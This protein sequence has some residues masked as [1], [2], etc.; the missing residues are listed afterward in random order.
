MSD[1]AEI[2]ALTTLAEERAL[3]DVRLVV[4]LGGYEGPLDLLLDLA[5]Q[6]K[7][8]LARISILALAEQYLDFIE[9]VR[10]LRIELAA[11]Y[12]LMAAWLA[13]L[14]SKLLL[15][16]TREAGEPSGEELA[17]SL[18]ERLRKLEIIR[19]AGQLLMARRRLGI[20]V[21]GRGAPEG[22]RASITSQWEAELI[23][24]L[25]AYA[26][27]R[28]KTELSRVT[29]RRRPVWSLA[30]AR[31]AL[32]RLVGGA[33]E[34]TRL[35]HYLLQYMVEPEQRVS[36]MASSFATSLEMVREGT[37]ELRQEGAFLPIFLRRPQQGDQKDRRH[38]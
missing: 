38:G 15:P 16:E 30:D 7:I 23:D 35:D 3:N 33:L 6:Q 4:D 34:W 26:T 25:K 19:E 8:D 13:F 28:S 12:L 18:A 14:K 21:L 1:T 5:R 20:D 31:Q 29:V 27:Q 37:V 32:E 24:L 11:D 22:V 17:Q 9:H 10:R 2:Q 36:V